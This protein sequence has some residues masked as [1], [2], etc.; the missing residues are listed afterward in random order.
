MKKTTNDLIKSHATDSPAENFI[1]EHAVNIGGSAV[2]ALVGLVVGGPVGAIIGATTQPLIT[3]SYQVFEKFIE[4]K[5][6]RIEK[7]LNDA[8]LTKNISEESLIDLITNDELKADN[9]I[10]LLR[11][12]AESDPGLDTVI[13]GMIGESLISNSKLQ[14][15][16]LLLIGDSIRNLRWVHLRTLYLLSQAGGVLSAHDIAQKLGLPELELRGVVRELE[17]RG[18]IKDLEKHPIQ[19]R[20]RELGEAIINF[21][22]KKF[23]T[24][25]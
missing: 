21:S 3:M 25:D 5:R 19:W 16:R 13:S 14:H 17:L 22:L 12:A 1:K 7:I 6:N 4:R 23:T 10:W 24:N 8:I 2:G 18:L 9:L 11:L 20:L 15:E